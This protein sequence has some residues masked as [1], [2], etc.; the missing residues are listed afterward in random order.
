MHSQGREVSQG[1]SESMLQ[2]EVDSLSNKLVE[3]QDKE[4]SLLEEIFGLRT[5]LE[6]ERRLRSESHSILDEPPMSG[7]G[8]V[9]V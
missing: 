2:T 6:S 1:K 9:M 4:N 5:T 3:A 8:S 7:P